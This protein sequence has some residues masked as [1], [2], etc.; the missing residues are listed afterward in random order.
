MI[1]L[2]AL[3]SALDESRAKTVQE[4]GTGGTER[5]R[6]PVPSPEPREANNGAASRHLEPVEP[7]EPE[8]IDVEGNAR[9]IAAGAASEIRAAETDLASRIQAMARRWNYTADELAQVIDAA[10]LDPAGWLEILAADE[11][12][13]IHQ[14]QGP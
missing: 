8:K 11:G 2:A 4:L 12:R 3:F 7:K 1:D 14:A 9:P 13:G 5:N 6:A 10:R